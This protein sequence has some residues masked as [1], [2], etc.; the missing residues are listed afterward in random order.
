MENCSIYSH[1]IWYKEIVDSILSLVTE[2]DLEITGE[3]EAWTAI[4]ILGKENA[5]KEKNKMTLT[6]RV[7]ETPNF[8]L[9]DPVDEITTNLNGMVNYFGAIATPKKV[10]LEKLI[11]KIS[12]INMEIGIV[13]ANGFNEIFEEIIFAITEKLEGFIFSNN[14]SILDAPD[15][16]NGIFNE[17]GDVILSNSGYSDV[18]DIEVLIETQYY[19]NQK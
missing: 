13:A 2:N 17:N 12:S 6:C 1:H 4:V 9:G 19:S 11:Y 3:A 5:R 8:E 7:R 15:S 14:N 18:N 10:L 16:Q